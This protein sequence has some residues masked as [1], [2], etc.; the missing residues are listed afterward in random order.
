M[1]RKYTCS[2]EIA[3]FERESQASGALVIF[4][5]DSLI[6]RNRLRISHL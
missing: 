1:E 5:R 2:A 6:L 4:I 3:S